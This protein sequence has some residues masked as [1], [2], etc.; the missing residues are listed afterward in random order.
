MLLWRVNRLELKKSIL[1]K[2]DAMNNYLQEL[3]EML[4][5]DVE[6]S[7]NLRARRA[8]E[9][10]IELVIE[11]VIDI[12]SMIVSHQK[13]GIPHSEDDLITVLVKKKILTPKLAEKIKVMKGFR[14]ILVHKYGEIDDQQ[15]Y[16]FLTTELDDFGLFEK[17]I[18][19]FL[20]S[21][22]ARSKK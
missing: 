20:G 22:Y 13:L 6:Y 19:L 14:N 7:R 15:V 3:E 1:E 18:K 5:E 12:C 16:Y 4:P 10:T 9:K 17:E 8:C 2:L 21:H 11:Q